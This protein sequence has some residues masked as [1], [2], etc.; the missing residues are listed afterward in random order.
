[1]KKLEKIKSLERDLNVMNRLLALIHSA[2]RNKNIPLYTGSGGKEVVL[3]RENS[4][5]GSIL[6]VIEEEAAQAAKQLEA[7][8]ENMFK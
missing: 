4:A 5:F 2:R 3:F 1:M 7:A 6:C 8:I